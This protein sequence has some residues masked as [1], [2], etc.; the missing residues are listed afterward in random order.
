[1]KK[2]G[3]DKKISLSEDTYKDLLEDYFTS[4]YPAGKLPSHGLE[5]HH[6]VWEYAKELLHY[7]EKD[8]SIDQIFID[9]L[10]I[11]CYLHDIGMSV[12]TGERHG[13]YSKDIC[14]KFLV[15]QNLDEN[16][17]KDLL[18][19]IENH[20]NKEY[21]GSEKKDLLLTVLSAADDLDAF[22]E[23]GISRYLEIYRT[24]G[25]EP[26]RIASSIRDNA[27]KRFEN[28]QR[29]FGKYPDLVA[30]HRKRYLLLYNYF[31]EN[32]QAQS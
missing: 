21:S 14:K 20:D 8:H 30:K 9:K 2:S 29:H 26:Y 3:I 18:S 23:K 17:Y 4:V 15:E 24:R 27:S 10:L 12:N 22:G 19:A 6:R 5:H 28:F 32:H 7:I 31:N 25:I 1:M 11:A 16:D 13:R